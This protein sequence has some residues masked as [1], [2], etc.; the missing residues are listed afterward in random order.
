MTPGSSQSFKR[1][2]QDT[3]KGYLMGTLVTVMMSIIRSSG[4]IYTK[5]RNLWA[6]LWEIVLV[7]LIGWK[8]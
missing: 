4:S 6:K 8:D 1:M 7:G 3:Q 5:E 2:K